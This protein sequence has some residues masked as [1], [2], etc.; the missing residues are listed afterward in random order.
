MNEWMDDALESIMLLFT[1]RLNWSWL[2]HSVVSQR[3]C[4]RVAVSDSCAEMSRHCRHAS[5]S[6]L[7]M[8]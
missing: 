5:T 4:R 2:G 7:S 8:K 3:R 1:H 6:H